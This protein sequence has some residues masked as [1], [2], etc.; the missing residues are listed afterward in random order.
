MRP[1]PS[2][3][4]GFAYA[5]H[6]LDQFIAVLNLFTIIL[7]NGDIIKY[8]PDNKDQFLEWLHSNDV[9]DIRKQDGWI[10]E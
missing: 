5:A 6:E 7:D 10:T 4:P 3:F 1:Q 8:E 9:K 2:F